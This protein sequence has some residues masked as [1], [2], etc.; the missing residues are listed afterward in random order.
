MLYCR[1]GYES[2]LIASANDRHVT[3]D[4]SV[5]KQLSI[6]KTQVASSV[7]E[8]LR[9]FQHHCGPDLVLIDDIL[10]D[11]S[12]L[13]LLRRM[14]Q[15]GAEAYVPC[16]MVS[17]QNSRDSVLHAI[18]AGCSGY[19]LRPYSI[20]TIEKHLDAALASARLP[21][22]VQRSF[23]NA[24][25]MLE[26]GNYAEAISE[27]AELVSEDDLAK[28]SFNDGTRQ[29]LVGNFGAAIEAFNKA[30]ALNRQYAEAH[31]GLAE[32]YKASG[33]MAGYQRHLQAAADIYAQQDNHQQVKELFVEILRLNPDAPNPYNT[34]GVRLRKSGDFENALSAYFQ[35]EELSPDDENLCYNIARAF[36]GL[37]DR[38]NALAYLERALMLNPD[39]THAEALYCRLKR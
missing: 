31:K 12:G 39:F 17:L 2:V 4:K 7:S 22:S 30:L 35:A 14:R 21:Q 15:E 9:P 34:L 16:V 26:Q 20:A 6:T 23:E 1:S 33:D 5:L 18:A 11:S 27:Y 38:R 24:R 8:A 10:E 36:L 3:V 25:K 32:V 29:L 13:E 37:D 28:Q 19:V